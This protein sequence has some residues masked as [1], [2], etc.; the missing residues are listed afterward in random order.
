MQWGAHRGRRVILSAGLDE[1]DVA[2]AAS[3]MNAEKV[4][5]VVASV[6]IGLS[7]EVTWR[8]VDDYYLHYGKEYP[9]GIQF[10]FASGPEEAQVAELTQMLTD[11][12][13]P[14]SGEEVLA[15]VDRADSVERKRESL[16]RLGVAAPADEE[17]RFL[18]KIIEAMHSGD[19]Q[20]REAGLWAAAHALWP[21]LLPEVESMSESEVN[22]VIRAQATA[23]AG[24]MRQEGIVP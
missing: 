13:E 14:P 11:Y 16:V 21:R 19:E 17:P 7:R 18:A 23:F 12:F 22:P 4:R 1:T 8:V 15:D 10:V 5:D 3:L 2:E 6:E 24:Y 9:F 20:V